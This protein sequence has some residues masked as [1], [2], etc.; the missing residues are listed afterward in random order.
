MFQVPWERGRQSYQRRWFSLK[1]VSCI[2]MLASFRFGLIFNT[3]L[4]RFLYLSLF[5]VCLFLGKGCELGS[6]L[7]QGGLF[8]FST[9]TPESQHFALEKDENCAWNNE[10][11]SLFSFLQE[12]VIDLHLFT[13]PFPTSVAEQCQSGCIGY[14]KCAH[15]RGTSTKKL[16]A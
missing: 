9:T 15:N 6:F 1:V 2:L 3:R 11:A 7:L 10:K 16:P 14:K 4:L 12:I 5:I 13:A 8:P